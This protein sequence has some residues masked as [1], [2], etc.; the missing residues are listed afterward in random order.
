MAD[1]GGDGASI[2]EVS[3]FS[4][5]LRRVVPVL[6]EDADDTP[7]ALNSALKDKA[8]IESM[9]KFLAD[10]QVQALLVQ[11]ISTKGNPLLKENN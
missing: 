1:T 7:E 8:S 5:Y 2:I 3:A 4:N 9:T 10:S 11:R 6:L